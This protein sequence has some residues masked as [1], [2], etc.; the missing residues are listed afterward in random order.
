MLKLLGKGHHLPFLDPSRKPFRQELQFEHP[1]QYT[2][3]GEGR[4]AGG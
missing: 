1:G 4:E 2:T 3:P